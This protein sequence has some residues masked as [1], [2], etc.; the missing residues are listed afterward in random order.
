MKRFI[1]IGEKL[2]HSYSVP[3]HE[4]FFRLLGIRGQYT[5]KEFDP[6][7]FIDI[8]DALLQLSGA[9]VTIPYKRT[10]I[11]YLDDYDISARSVGAVN[12]IENLH[13]RLIGHNTDVGGLV[14]MLDYHGFKVEGRPCAILGA[15]GASKAAEAA[16]RQMGASSVRVFSRTPELKSGTHP[17]DDLRHYRGGLLVNCTPVGMYPNADA[18]PVS[19]EIVRHFDEGV[20]MIYNPKE[21]LFSKAFEK[22][23][24]GLYMLVA[25]A[26]LAQEIW[27]QEP[28]E[29]DMIETVYK[30]MLKEFQ[31][32]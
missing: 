2:S 18:C 3:I 5:L 11:P 30:N 6:R 21:T 26:A 10:I 24:T 4:A 15:G 9:N 7:A 16:L 32:L 14:A 22:S 29:S 27:F 13:G 25:Q 28:I 19:Q 1:L 17:Y 20:D 23:A 8:R 12:T 31:T